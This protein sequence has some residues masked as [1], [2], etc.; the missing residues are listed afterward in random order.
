MHRRIG[1]S[2]MRIYDNT[3]LT[4][5]VAGEAPIALVILN[6]TGLVKGFE[7]LWPRATITICAD[8]GANKLY[9]TWRAS[10]KDEPWI[11][12]YVKG[13]LDSLRPDVSAFFEARGTVIIKDPDQDTNDLDKCLALLESLQASMPSNDDGDASAAKLKVLMLG[14]MGGRF[15]Q[16]IQNISALYRWS[17][18]FESMTL[19][20]DHTSV[21]LLPPGKH[22]I[23]PNFDIESRTCG[24]IPLSGTCKALT[25]Q[26]LKWDMTDFETAISGFVSSSNH[27]LA[28]EI[29]VENSD[30]L[31][32]TTE[33]RPDASS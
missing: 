8:G 30:P 7:A 10:G 3:C 19:F 6:G 4:R 17:H 14:A 20:S 21:M 16:E 32:W 28:D 23:R 1:S 24:L 13:D 26:G 25:T 27:C 31:I 9:D 12:Q 5:R 29:I 15:D 18:V 33:I 11:P 22:C 2:L